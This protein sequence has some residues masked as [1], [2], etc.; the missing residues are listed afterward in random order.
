MVL[1]GNILFTPWAVRRYASFGRVVLRVLLAK[2]IP[3]NVVFFH[4][5]YQEQKQQLDRN[6][7][8]FSSVERLL[9]IASV[10]NS[11]KWGH[12]KFII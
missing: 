10:V 2:S 8:E 6:E 7:H 12:F 5:E 4:L 11:G 9:S 1:S 3:V